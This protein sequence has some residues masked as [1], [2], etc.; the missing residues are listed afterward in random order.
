MNFGTITVTLK[1]TEWNEIRPKRKN[2]SKKW[3]QLQGQDI[4]KTY[5][6]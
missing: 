4:D 1:V 2:Y 5:T 6:Y 3:L